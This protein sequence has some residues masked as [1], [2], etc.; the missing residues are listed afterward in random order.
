LEKLGPF[1]TWYSSSLSS[2]LMLAGSNS[3]FRYRVGSLANAS[4]VGAKT[5]NGQYSVDGQSLPER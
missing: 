1:T 5:V 2:A 4:L 3:S